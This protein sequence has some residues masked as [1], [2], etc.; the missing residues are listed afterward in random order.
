MVYHGL[1]WYTMVY[2]SMPTMVHHGTPWCTMVDGMIYHGKPWYIIPVYHGVPW[3]TM[4]YHG[5]DG[6]PCLHYGIAEELIHLK[7]TITKI[8]SYMTDETCSKAR[9]SQRQCGRSTLCLL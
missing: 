2:D 6:I 9:R 4:V 7:Y 8:S 1:P 5:N 3:Y